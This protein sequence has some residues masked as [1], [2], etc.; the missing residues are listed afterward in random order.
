MSVPSYPQTDLADGDPTALFA[1]VAFERHR[2]TRDETRPVFVDE[3]SNFTD[4]CGPESGVP[5]DPWRT[6]VG[7]GGLPCVQ[8]D[9]RLSAWD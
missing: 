8:V 1:R 3:C 2:S 7:L 9:S 6:Q 4:P 5:S